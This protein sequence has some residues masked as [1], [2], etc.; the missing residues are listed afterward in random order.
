M[1]RKR[2]PGEWERNS[3]TKISGPQSA[4]KVLH[5]RGLPAFTTEHELISLCSP[6][7]AVLGCV[8]LPNKDQGF[9]QMESIETATILLNT[10]EYVKP[11]IHSKPV[12][13]QFSRFDQHSFLI[14]V[15]FF[16]PF[17]IS[18][19]YPVSSVINNLNQKHLLAPANQIFQIILN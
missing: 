19:F 13:F 15:P 12:F 6:H 8:I 7:G 3:R 2:D 11:S 9:V 1:I 18:L 10:F 17:S 4:S 5:V 16:S 14:S